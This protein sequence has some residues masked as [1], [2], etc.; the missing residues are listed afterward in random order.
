[1]ID[2]FSIHF[3]EAIDFTFYRS[4]KM[5]RSLNYIQGVGMNFEVVKWLG[6]KKNGRKTIVHFPRVGKDV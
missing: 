2:I 4:G 3:L 1:M 6:S 5:Q